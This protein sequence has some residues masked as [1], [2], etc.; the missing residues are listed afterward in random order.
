MNVTADESKAKFKES[1]ASGSIDRKEPVSM[2]VG[3]VDNLEARQH[4]EALSEELQVRL[5]PRSP[6]MA[7]TTLASG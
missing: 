3:C 5:A 4:M 6:P 7:D 2:L 1:L